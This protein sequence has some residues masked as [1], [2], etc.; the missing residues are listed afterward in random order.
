MILNVTDRFLTWEYG[1]KTQHGNRVYEISFKHPPS[2]WDTIGGY[3][4]RFLEES[5]DAKG[6]SRAIGFALEDVFKYFPDKA[7]EQRLPTSIRVTYH[8]GWEEFEE[9]RKLRELQA[10]IDKQEKKTKKEK[11]EKIVWTSLTD[12]RN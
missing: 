11:K 2:D 3:S 4:I 5:A 1:R 6:E 7:I 10:E 8:S 9:R 12:L